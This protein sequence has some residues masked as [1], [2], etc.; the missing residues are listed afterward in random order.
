MPKNLESGILQNDF[1]RGFSVRL[2]CKDLRLVCEAIR[3]LKTDSTFTF[4]EPIWFLPFLANL[5]KKGVGEQGN[6]TQSDLGKGSSQEGK[7]V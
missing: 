2:Q 6:Q 4:Q 3:G 7:D 1:A 5:P